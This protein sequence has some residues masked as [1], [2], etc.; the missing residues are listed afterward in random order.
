M[1]IL[2]TRVVINL[3][4]WNKEVQNKKPLQEKNLQGFIILLCGDAE[5]RTRVQ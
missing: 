3:K 5:S 4:E 2:S 1:Q